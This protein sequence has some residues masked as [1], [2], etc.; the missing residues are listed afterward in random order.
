M[1][2]FI[3]STYV[4]SE[5][6]R[7]AFVK[8]LSTKPAAIK[9]H[10]H[11]TESN[12]LPINPAIQQANKHHLKVGE[13]PTQSFFDR[14][15]HDLFEGASDYLTWENAIAAGEMIGSLVFSGTPKANRQCELMVLHNAREAMRKC[16]ASA[17][18][19]VEIDK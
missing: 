19:I 17:D 13:E 2:R 3:S 4:Y 10:H 8:W 12:N 15:T 1:D 16:E 14:M 6:P 18:I 7:S 11:K 5:R 9:S